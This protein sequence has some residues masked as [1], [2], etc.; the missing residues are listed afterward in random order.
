LKQAVYVDTA[1]LVA[2]I[3]VRDQHNEE[4]LW[5]AERL[6]AEDA[7]LVSTDAVILELCN[8]FARSPLRTEAIAWVLEVR[9]DPGWE[10]V[11]VDR[12]L[13]SAAERRYQAHEDKAWSLTDCIGMELMRSRKL[14]RA[15]TTDVGFQQAG[16]RVLMGHRAR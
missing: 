11:S 7:P 15:A 6:A 1:W 3:D 16:F 12:R 14:E 9:G 10:V 8:Y 5:L 4:A 2:L 13:L